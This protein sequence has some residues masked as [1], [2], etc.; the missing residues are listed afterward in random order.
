MSEYSARGLCVRAR[1]CSSAVRASF[2]TTTATTTTMTDV[3]S[4]F[5][6]YDSGSD[7]YDSENSPTPVKGKVRAT[8]TTTTRGCRV[9]RFSFPSMAMAMRWRRDVG[10]TRG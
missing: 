6:E 2:A 5:S 3:D 8:T 1:V 4:E 7:F 10:L 9:C